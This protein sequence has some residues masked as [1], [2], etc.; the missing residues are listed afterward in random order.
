MSTSHKRKR[1]G[2][3]EDEPDDMAMA[4][5]LLPVANL[6]ADFN[7]E[8]EDGPQYLFLVRR[9]ARTLPMS[10]RV[11]NPYELPE[12]VEA[13]S[14]S[15][16]SSSLLPDATWRRDFV[17]NFKN[18]RQ[19]ILQPTIHVTVPPTVHGRKIMPDKKQRGQWWAFL[20]GR[21]QSEWNPP[22]KASKQKD[23][24][25]QG[26][27][28]FSSERV[29][30]D[31]HNDTHLPYD[32]S[33]E[34]WRINDEGEVEK[35]LIVDP[36][37]S[38]PTPSGTPAPIDP[39]AMD[40]TSAAV[41]VTE[42]APAPTTQST[43]LRPTL[44][45][46]SQIDHKYSLHLVMYFTH[47]INTYLE[48]KPGALCPTEVHGIWIFSLLA[49]LEESISADDM[50]LVRHLARACMAYLKHS[51]S[52]RQPLMDARRGPLLTEKACWIVITIVADVLVQSDLWTDMESILKAA[53]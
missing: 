22:K 47:W 43:A 48:Q 12:P 10:T 1:G 27:R 26:M 51:L 20:E 18:Y 35:A 32:N 46:L 13:D 7:E 24:F 9:D 11:P 29:V 38:L 52:G 2:D 8:P 3:Y 41:S 36:T 42:A 39:Q 6:P 28:G 53:A 17:D 49:R 15:A 30:E 34:T 25:S 37:D 4:R 50:N 40:Y 19:N 31:M 14:G 16:S 44:S 33:Q 23:N 45:L 21:P 5:Q